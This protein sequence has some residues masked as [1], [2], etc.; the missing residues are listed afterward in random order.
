MAS[1]GATPTAAFRGL[2]G[3]WLELVS[4]LASQMGRVCRSPGDWL[5]SSEPLLVSVGCPEAVG[6]RSGCWAGC[7][8]DL[9]FAPEDCGDLCGEGAPLQP[10]PAC[11]AGV[12][13]GTAL[14]LEFRGDLCHL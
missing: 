8:S 5:W 10:E 4:P 14:S 6:L 1:W 2:G 3:V 9:V 7:P 13:G 11:R 12:S